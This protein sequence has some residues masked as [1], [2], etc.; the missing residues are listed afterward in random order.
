MKKIDEEDFENDILYKLARRGFW[1][2]V[3][4]DLT[5]LYRGRGHLAGV[6]KKLAK[7]LV[8]KGFLIPKKSEGRDHVSLN[9]R[10]RKEIIER[11]EKH[12]KKYGLP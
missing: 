3:H 1:G 10:M 6:F 4:T 12:K 7:N 11:I 8:K 9:P 2:A 5:H